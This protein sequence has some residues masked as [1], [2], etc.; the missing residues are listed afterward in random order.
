MSALKAV[1]LCNNAGVMIVWLWE[2]LIPNC[3]GFSIRRIDK[4]TGK[5]TVLNSRLVRFKGEEST[6]TE[7]D[8]DSHPIQGCKWFD[9]VDEGATVQYEIVPRVGKPGNLKDGE[10]V[11]TNEVTLGFDYGPYVKAC[12]NRGH[13]VST[14]WVAE[15]LPKLADGKPDPA[16]LIAAI[17]DPESEIAKLLG[18][19]LPTFTR[20]PYEDAKRIAG[21]V[22]ALYYELS[23]PA[24]VQY[25]KDNK[26]VWSMVLGNAGKDDATNAEAREELHAIG[27]DVTDRMLPSSNLPHNKSAVLVGPDGKP[28]SWMLQSANHTKTGYYTQANHGL[29]ITSEPF[30]A[31]GVDYYDRTKADCD[32]VQSQSAAYRKANAAVMSPV[33]LGDGTEVQAIF[34]PSSEVRSKPKVEKGQ[35]T[36]PLLEMAASTAKVKEVL[37]KAKQGVYFLAFYPGAP[38]FLDVATWLQKKKPHLY[39]RGAVSSAQALP[40]QQEGIEDDAFPDIQRLKTQGL[41]SLLDVSHPSEI[42]NPQTAVALFR[43]RKKTPAIIAAAAL[44]NGWEDWHAELLKLPDAH[45]IIH[46]KVIVVDPFGD[47]PWVLGA[48]SDNLGLKAG[49][50]NDETMLA[51]RGNKRLAQAYFVHIMDVYSHFMWRYL[52]ATGR[53]TFSGELSTTSTWQRKYLSGRTHD[54]YASWLEGMEE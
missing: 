43:P 27:A 37:L 15:K 30:A 54:E 40:K 29:Y 13:L 25:L 8:T 34:S 5:K 39:I 26:D 3:L 32:D 16:A 53:S 47:D 20:L 12:F 9:G 49:I 50:A 14:Q 19:S 42:A 41:T 24:M 2:E 35:R 18:A 36:F 17:E 23:S 1:A 4:A 33:D 44:E 28:V 46:S 6:A 45:A 48:A 38:S 22:L 11:L 52:L 7:S 21:H 51:I 10:A 31:V